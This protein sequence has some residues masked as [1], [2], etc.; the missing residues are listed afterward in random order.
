MIKKP[1]NYSKF[2]YDFSIMLLLISGFGF[3]Q[4]WFVWICASCIGLAF[5]M[6]LYAFYLPEKLALVHKIW[7]GF[8]NILGAVFSPLVLGVIFFGLITPIAIIAR[9]TGRDVLNIRSNAM[10]VGSN[11]T[12]WKSRASANNLPSQTQF[13]DQF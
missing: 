12:F 4:K 7:F 2:G 11:S 8:A 6:S 10:A 3:Y 13:I 5:W 1:I 9:L